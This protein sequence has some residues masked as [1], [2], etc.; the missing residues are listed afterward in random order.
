MAWMTSLIVGLCHLILVNSAD[1]HYSVTE[2]SKSGLLVGNIPDSI[3]LVNLVSQASIPYMKYSFL[4]IDSN[5]RKYFSLNEKSG[6][7]RLSSSE[8]LDREAVCQFDI[9]CNLE[10][11]IAIQSTHTQF[12][13]K[14][15]VSIDVIDINDHVPEFKENFTTLT[16]SESVQIP[17][18]FPLPSAIDKDTGINNSLQGYE[19]FPQDG[20]FELSYSKSNSNLML[21]VVKELDHEMRDLYTVKIIARD[22]GDPAREGVLNVD[23]IVEDINDNAPKFTQDKYAK[24]VDETVN[25]GSLLL[26]L[27]AVDADSGKNGQVRYRLS[28]QQPAHILSMFS[29]DT[30]LGELRLVGDFQYAETELYKIDVEASDMGDQPF[31]TKTTVSI[32]VED[33]INSRPKL[34]VSYLSQN[35]YSSISEYANLGVAVAHILVKDTDRGPNGIVQCNLTSGGYFELQSYDIKEYKVIV[36]R[37][38]DREVIQ[39]HNVTIECTDAGLPSLSTTETFQVRVIDENDNAPIFP[40]RF[41]NMTIRENNE[42]GREILTVAAMDADDRATGNGKITYSL[43]DVSNGQLLI[44]PDTGVIKAMTSFDYELKRQINFTVVADDNGIPRRSAK[45]PVRVTILDENDQVPYFAQSRFTIAVSEYASRGDLIGEITA[46]DF[47]QGRNGQFEITKIPGS[48]RGKM[49]H[50][51][52]VYYSGSVDN[53]PVDL[54]KLDDDKIPFE[55]HHNGSLILLG[56]LD[57]EIR[58][59]YEFEVRVTDKGEPPLSDTATVVIDV[60][61]END[62]TPYILHP[63][64]SEVMFVALT[65]ADAPQTLFSFE[66]LDRDSGS[67]SFLVYTVTARNDSGR[68]DVDSQGEVK[69][70]RD[71]SYRD[72]GTYKLS[73]MVRDSGTPPLSD[74]RTVLIHISGGNGTAGRSGLMKD[75]YIVIALTLVCVT[76]LLS[77]T[78]IL[79]IVIMRRLDKRRKHSAGLTPRPPMHIPNS[80]VITTFMDPVKMDNFRHD[81]ANR[82]YRDDHLGSMGNHKM[83]DSHFGFTSSSGS[84]N[85]NGLADNGYQ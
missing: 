72:A 11:Q 24:V 22:G 37:S 38:L 70:T 14:V 83:N 29:V 21:R 68:F 27:K 15:L 54:E 25:P 26:T 67:N 77:V 49:T 79:I 55:V 74:V 33:T 44:N 34:L 42:I 85:K 80:R 56:E 40:K 7:L 64:V 6:D 84:I 36:A 48:G 71:F 63:N 32:T 10:L 39:V 66:V 73:V 51:S 65:G 35:N 16:I 47:E 41:Y 5:L 13:R 76:I 18:S 60:T 45:V 1:V 69:R 30:T 78:I 53:S 31:T 12:F 19:I 2:Q 57:H 82:E 50:K 8:V 9:T 58:C 75:Q 81:S 46:F 43:Q 28:P 59:S 23:I 3:D 20:P 17:S 52:G 4:S 61:D 62:N